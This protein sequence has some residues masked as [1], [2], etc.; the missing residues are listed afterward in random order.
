MPNKKQKPTDDSN[1]KY[2]ITE[3]GHFQM[4]GIPTFKQWYSKYV[5]NL[6]VP[7]TKKTY[8]SVQELIENHKDESAWLE[9]KLQRIYYK[10][11][12]LGNKPKS[13]MQELKWFKQRGER[14]WSDCDCWSI[15]SYISG[16]LL[17]MLKNYKNNLCGLPTSMF[18]KSDPIKKTGEY[19]KKAMENAEKRWIKE[20]DKMIYTFE[21]ANKITQGKLFYQSTSEW[22][23]RDFDRY[24]SFDSMRAMTK[25]EC[26]KYEEGWQS[27]QKH[28]FELWS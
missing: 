11:K 18:R 17:S 16:V 14:G 3:T 10:L 21:V 20:V 23:K 12:D 7:S 24:N 25:T 5:W 4:T 9:D 27:F 28:F 1:I 13:C 6:N 15:D 26:K 22:D 2:E 19:T 8:K